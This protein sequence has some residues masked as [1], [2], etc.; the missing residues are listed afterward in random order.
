MWLPH[1]KVYWVLSTYEL[2]KEFYF[3]LTVTAELRESLN[4]PELLVRLVGA[5]N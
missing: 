3:F 4:H 2:C 5:I 1:T